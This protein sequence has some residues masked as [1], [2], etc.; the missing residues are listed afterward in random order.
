MKF[1]RFPHF[2]DIETSISTAR[3]TALISE[4]EDFLGVLGALVV[5]S[6]GGL[7]SLLLT[8]YPV[9]EIERPVS[10]TKNCQRV[11]S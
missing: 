11:E 3:K 1:A 2:G 10:A 4:T 7:R 9:G 8:L 6:V 5:N